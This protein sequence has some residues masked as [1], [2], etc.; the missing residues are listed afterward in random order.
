MLIA[1][2]QHGGENFLGVPQQICRGHVQAYDERRRAKD[3]AREAEEE[4]LAAEVFSSHSSVLID[5]PTY[6]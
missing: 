1:W 3:A 5:L 2:K 4:A 6:F